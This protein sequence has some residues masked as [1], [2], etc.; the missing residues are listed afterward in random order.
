MYE[1]VL[2]SFELSKREQKE[3]P[4]EYWICRETAYN[5]SLIYKQRYVRAL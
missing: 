5:L 4:P 3:I 2:R 1:R